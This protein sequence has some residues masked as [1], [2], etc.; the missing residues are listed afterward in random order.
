MLKYL[1][2]AAV[3]FSTAAMAQARRT[4]GS[5]T[6]WNAYENQNGLVM[7]TAGGQVMYL[8]KDCDA[9]HVIY[10]AGN[11]QWANGGFIVFV[12]GRS[13]G[14]ARQDPPGEASYD[15]CWK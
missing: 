9:F 5:G 2:I 13:F 12:G 14:F 7:T 6:T 15:K 8:G 3:L 11:W 10:G 4:D 1:T